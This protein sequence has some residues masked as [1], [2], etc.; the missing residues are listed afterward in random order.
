MYVSLL[1][2]DIIVFDMLKKLRKANYKKRNIGKIKK[3][4]NDAIVVYFVS[5][6]EMEM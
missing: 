1:F 3:R 5:N 6:V 4:I 2:I